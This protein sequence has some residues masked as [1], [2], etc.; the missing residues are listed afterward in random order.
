[1]Q[2]ALFSRL[3]ILDDVLIFQLLSLGFYVNYDVRLTYNIILA[4]TCILHNVKY[5][6]VLDLAM[7][8]YVTGCLFSTS[9]IYRDERRQMS[10]GSLSTYSCP[11]ILQVAS[12][13]LI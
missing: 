2:P 10:I 12:K 13:A 7:S 6:V 5:F 11:N 9:D 4:D 8:L 1:M 3:M